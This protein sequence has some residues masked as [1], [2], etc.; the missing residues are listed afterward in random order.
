MSNIKHVLLEKLIEKDLSVY[1]LS[2][3]INIPKSRI[4]A[5]TQGRAEPKGEDTLKIVQFF[6][7]VQIPET[8]ETL[9]NGTSG[10]FVNQDGSV[11]KKTK[12]EDEEKQP[13][14]KNPPPIKE[15]GS[16]TTMEVILNLSRSTV[17]LAEANRDQT[18]LLKAQPSSGVSLDYR[19]EVEISNRIVRQ[20]ASELAGKALW[21]TESEGLTILSKLLTASLLGVKE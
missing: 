7:L 14:D 15:S 6:K 3:K 2:K 20:L 4:Y 19:S 11:I 1:S 10:N 13:I 17:F 9:K 5:W 12:M 16:L 18:I 8:A 21:K